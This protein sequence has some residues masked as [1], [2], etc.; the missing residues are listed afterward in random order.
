ML[1][2]KKVREQLASLPADL[3][4]EKDAVRKLYKLMAVEQSEEY[5]AAAKALNAKLR[6]QGFTSLLV[7]EK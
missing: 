6:A 2:P 1:V 7:V 3:A 4:A 5:I